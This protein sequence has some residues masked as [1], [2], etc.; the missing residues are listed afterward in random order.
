MIIVSS[1]DSEFISE[2]Y[3]EQ[4]IIEGRNKNRR[5]MS[6]PKEIR[7]SVKMT[8]TLR[9]DDMRIK[10]KRMRNF[11]TIVALMLSVVL[12]AQVNTESYFSV[13]APAS[14]EGVNVGGT[15]FSTGSTLTIPETDKPVTTLKQ[16]NV[17][18]HLYLKLDLGED[19]VDVG[20]SDFKVEVSVAITSTNNVP[21]G[22]SAIPTINQDLLIDG[23]TPEK[24]Y[25]IDLLSSIAQLGSDI[26]IN[27]TSLAV[28]DG[29]G[30]TL[31]SG[32]LKNYIDNHLRLS[33]NF[34]REYGVDVRLETSGLV[35]DI[36]ETP[37][38]NIV[39]RL[40]TFSWNAPSG[41]IGYPN[42]EL[43]ILRL[44]NSNPDNKTLNNKIAAEINWAN[45]LRVETQTSETEIALTLAEGTGFY[46]WR[47]RPIGNFYPGG[48]ANQ[49]NYG[50]WSNSFSNG[51]TQTIQLNSIGGA[52]AGTY[53][54]SVF[55]FTDP[56]EDINWIYNRV[57][58][59]GNND[60]TV[61]QGIKTSEGM[62]YADGLLRA[63][64]TQAFNSSNNTTLITQTVSDYSGRPALT[65]LP[66]PVVDGLVGYKTNFVQSSN[67]TTYTALDFDTDAN[68]QTPE[69]I[70]DNGTDFNYYDG[71]DG[72]TISSG[73]NN[74]G[75]ADAEGYAF[76]RT[77]FKPDGTGR[78]TEESGVGRIHALGTSGNGGGKTTKVVFASASDHELIRIFGDEAP[79]A[80]SVIKTITTD[81][82]G[83][84]SVT[85]TSKEGKT[86]ATAMIT[87]EIE[88]DNGKTILD[89][90]NIGGSS[91]TVHNVANQNVVSNQKLI[92]SKRIAL[93]QLKLVTLNYNVVTETTMGGCPGGTCDLKV[94]F[95]LV[96]LGSGE[97]FVSDQTVG[98][99]T[100]N[101]FDMAG[102]TLTFPGTWGW[103]EP[104]NHTTTGAP[105]ITAGASFELAAGEYLLIKEV[106]SAKDPN[107]VE[108]EIAETTDRLQPVLD[109]I[110]DKMR[111]IESD[112]DYDDFVAFFAGDPTATAGTNERKGVYGLV[113]EYQLTLPA[114]STAAAIT[115]SAPLV[116]FLDLDV[117]E[118]TY[119]FPEEFNF[120]DIDNNG[121][122]VPIADPL[123]DDPLDDSQS[124]LSFGLS[125]CGAMEI[126]VPKPEICIPCGALI[127]DEY[128]N[129]FD[130]IDQLRLNFPDAST[131][132]FL[133]L[134]GTHD[135]ANPGWDDVHTIVE[136]HF[137]TLLYSKLSTDGFIQEFVDLSTT[138]FAYDHNNPLNY[139]PSLDGTLQPVLDRFAPGFTH[140]S[141]SNMLTNMLVSQ[142]YT[143]N[144]EESGGVKYKAILD[145]NGGLVFATTGA[146]GELEEVANASLAELINDNNPF[147]YDCKGLYNGWV[148][149]VEMINA[150]EFEDDANTMDSYNDEEGEG[151]SEEEYDDEENA[152][153]PGGVVGFFANLIISAKMRGFQDGP[154]GELPVARM[155]SLVNLPTL[156]LTH[157]AVGYQFASIL[158]EDATIP[159]DYASTEGMLGSSLPSS[160]PEIV[161]PTVFGSHFPGT[162]TTP[163]A[164]A[165]FEV[166]DSD[167]LNI[168]LNPYV[169][170]ECP[171]NNTP[172]RALQYK[173]ILKPEWMFKYFV[174]NAFA[175][176]GLTDDDALIINQF[177]AEMAGCYNDPRDLY[178][179]IPEGM[180]MC[181]GGPCNYYHQNWSAEE[182]YTFYK[183]ISGG[184]NCPPIALVDP[185]VTTPPLIT[186]AELVAK[187]NQELQEAVDICNDRAG[188]IKSA[189]IEELNNKCYTFVECK[190]A[191]SPLYEITEEQVNNM[192]QAVVDGCVAKVEAIVNDL[193]DCSSG[194]NNDALNNSGSGVDYGVGST[195]YPYYEENGCFWVAPS[196]IQFNTLQTVTLFKDCDVELLEQLS[197]WTFQPQIDVAIDL[198][199]PC[200]NANPE[201]HWID[202]T[203]SVTGC[204]TQSCTHNG[205]TQN[206]SAVRNVSAST[207]I[208]E[209][210]LPGQ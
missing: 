128:G 143:G 61:T 169:G 11:L 14:L 149:S 177:D 9:R 34:V 118:L 104:E 63:R 68:Y 94:R 20:N 72:T 24:L 26:E 91:L 173:Y 187:A 204:V 64:Q 12:R 160:T 171:P 88:D 119:I 175:K 60:P 205:N 115:N 55:H 162:I 161:L 57:F 49:E 79:L 83:V 163:A 116:N 120:I 137:M 140:E 197:S 195:N 85:Y 13:P 141:L 179:T 97:R 193:P 105:A 117:D 106:Y 65:T 124:I 4:I 87:N 199:E 157:P 33:A 37:Q 31:G 170:L 134:D 75:V 74:D 186:K 210:P 23:E 184:L 17:S 76:K 136:E 77:L 165:L 1:S 111:N 107:F 166:D 158:D 22:Y 3:R 19:Y 130:G 113:N 182:R 198:P 129:T 92:S 188:E 53:T 131:E 135:V 89:S 15:S 206:Y 93:E 42:Y 73:G 51:S 191:T 35:A 181:F 183:Q 78:V 167:P 200:T 28:T 121:N 196:G 123:M 21:A 126:P 146:N 30:V 132:H 164:P 5:S 148:Q 29:A 38:V 50:Q 16:N 108:V 189:L 114:A 40:A 153:G 138:Q 194:C 41:V 48:I 54:G 142:Y 133:E 154:D 44:Y 58:T 202:G 150:F 103:V 201:K 102:G 25:K 127:G 82:N 208:T 100:A 67:N 172:S 144:T 176:T 18:A 45:A 95:H 96:N 185:V 147:N 159:V 36:L 86:I 178:T 174:Y 56:D 39:N 98:D 71:D 101:A 80:E 207:G 203:C 112:D 156:F 209:S 6:D 139:D 2:L 81:P 192:A 145:D 32:I 59:E 122:P 90:L 110:A 69:Q 180:S 155:E 43:Q 109:A 52:N 62:S 168:V 151:E 125:C 152:D 7:N 10:N 99:G 27:V 47:V 190:T 84:V 46:I 66:V 70:E 8:L